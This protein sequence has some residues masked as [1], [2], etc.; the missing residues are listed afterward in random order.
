MYELGIYIYIRSPTSDSSAHILPDSR[1]E[2]ARP[3]PRR[4]STAPIAAGALLR[5][6][7]RCAFREAPL[8]LANDSGL[9]YSQAVPTSEHMAPSM[10]CWRRVNTKK[11]SSLLDSDAVGGSRIEGP[12]VWAD[13]R[14]KM[15]VRVRRTICSHG[16]DALSMCPQA[17]NFVQLNLPKFHQLA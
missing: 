9:A 16:H 14:V 7:S 6:G 11:M 12:S 10:A 5:T 3:P 1:T 4:G 17:V 13:T 2:Y 8:Q 15:H